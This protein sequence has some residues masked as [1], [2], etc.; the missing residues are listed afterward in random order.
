M[1]NDLPENEH[2]A[3]TVAIPLV[4]TVACGTPM[5]AEENIEAMIPVSTSLAKPGHRY[6]LLR[7]Q[8]D[9]M[10]AAEIHDG[11]LVLVRQQQTANN[12]NIVVALIDEEATIKEFRRTTE[13]VVLQPKSNSPEYKPIILTREFQIQ[14]VVVTTIPKL[15]F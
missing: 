1:L 10:N 6:F 4:G 7:A 3:R 8:G 11:D 15:N 12:G 2:H 13:V 5:L 9:S 14:G